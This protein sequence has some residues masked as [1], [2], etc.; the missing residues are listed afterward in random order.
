[1]NKIVVGLLCGRGDTPEAV[2]TIEA[3]RKA[4]HVGPITPLFGVVPSN[5]IRGGAY[6]HMPDASKNK[7][8]L[9]R[10]EL[11]RRM[12]RMFSRADLYV[13]LDDDTRPEPG[14]FKHLAE[15]EILADPVLMGGK[16]LNSD[17]QR[18]W[19]VCSFQEN[20]PVVVPYEM[21]SHPIWYK[22]LY[23]SGPQ[24]VFNRPGV[25]LAAK[26]GYPDLEYGEDTNFCFNFKAAQ[27]QIVF[28]AE[29][30]AKLSHLH[31]P[32]NEVMWSATV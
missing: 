15:M 5:K 3:I 10:T 1:M 24:H 20:N 2:G 19:D 17:G 23:L 26:I 12:A 14:Y 27:G 28:I 29:I 9:A 8:G 13:F 21:W 32:P 31:K 22:D 6:I 25:E 30:T 7:R 4:G 11:V 16:L 18:S